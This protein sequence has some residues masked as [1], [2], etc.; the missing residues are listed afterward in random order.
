MVTVEVEDWLQ[1]QKQWADKVVQLQ[2]EQKEL[3]TG[4]YVST[5]HCE[6]I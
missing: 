6:L 3:V 1:V 5:T 4:N 2:A